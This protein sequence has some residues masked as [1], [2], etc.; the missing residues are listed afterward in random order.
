MKVLRQEECMEKE[1]QLEMRTVRKVETM[2]K[3]E[4]EEVQECMTFHMKTY[5]HDHWVRWQGVQA[6]MQTLGGQPWGR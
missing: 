2:V 1:R 5:R 6:E 4:Q 3:V